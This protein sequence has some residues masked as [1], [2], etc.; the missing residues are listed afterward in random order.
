MYLI[1]FFLKCKSCPLALHFESLLICNPKIIQIRFIF[2]LR[3]QASICQITFPIIPFFQPTVIEH[4]QIIFNDE[5]NDIIFQTFLKHNQTSYTTVTV[6][7]RMDS[8]KLN[9]KIK[10]ILQSLFFFSVVL[11]QQSFHFIGNFFWKCG[12]HSANFVRHL[13]IIAYSKPIFSGIT[14]TALQN[15]L[16]FFDKL[17][18]KSSLIN[19]SVRAALALSIII[20]IQRK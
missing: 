6:L 16:K 9:M 2:I 11:S 19:F 5:R 20:S 1:Y 13:F 4:L 14:G 18:C 3:C 12:F 10:D 7:E 17:L 8:L 15:Q